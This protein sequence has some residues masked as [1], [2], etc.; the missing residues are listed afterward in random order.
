MEH[1]NLKEKNHKLNIRILWY[2]IPEKIISKQVLVFCH[3]EDT[4][5]ENKHTPDLF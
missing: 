1:L 4:L 3:S 2:Y 5:A